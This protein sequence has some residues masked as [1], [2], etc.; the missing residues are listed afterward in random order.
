VADLSPQVRD[1][2]GVGVRLALTV[3][4]VREVRGAAAHRKAIARV[5]G[6]RSGVSTLRGQASVR[7]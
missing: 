4:V 5:D 1:L 7:L 3:R 2:L 6:R